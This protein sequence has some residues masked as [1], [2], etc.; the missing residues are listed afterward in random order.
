MS[1]FQLHGGDV[2]R[3]RGIL[4]FSANINPLGMPEGVRE[5]A[6]RGV[7]D[8]EH[9]PDPEEEELKQ[10][11]AKALDVSEDMLIPGNGAAELIRIIP[12]VLCAGGG[13]RGGLIRP[14]FGEYE[15]G[16]RLAGMAI[17]EIDFEDAKAGKIPEGLDLV[18]LGNPSNPDG[19]SFT[20]QELTKIAGANPR[21]KVIIDESFLPF[22]RNEN[23]RTCIPCLREY[24]NMAVIRSFTK[25]FA[26]PGLRLGVLITADDAFGRRARERLQPWTV[27]LPAQ[28][29]GVAALSQKSFVERTVAFL[30]AER[31]RMEAEIR[32][33]S[34][35]DRV[36]P[37]PAN[38]L[39]FHVREGQPHRLYQILLEKNIQVRDCSSFSGMNRLAFLA[40]E[41]GWYRVAVRTREENERLLAAMREV[42]AHLS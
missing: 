25:I 8:S 33:L 6:V 26:M 20:R 22:A 9:Y 31:P 17:R 21:T 15:T 28:R 2:Y 38:F 27:S 14:C 16:M 37:S 36:F 7:C 19:R 40:G 4:D 18:F 42:A 23:E 24:Q 39:L 5:A 11:C 1:D 34:F 12:E 30:N 35:V 13:A 29:A 10:A 41:T 3:R 32:G